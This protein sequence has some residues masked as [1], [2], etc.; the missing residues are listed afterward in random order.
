[1]T[2][3]LEV[4]CL[5]CQVVVESY[6]VVEPGDT[7]EEGNNYPSNYF[8][9]PSLCRDCAEDLVELKDLFRGLDIH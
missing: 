2:V 4:R 8:E 1:M 6:E 7:V 5:D 9:I 3:E